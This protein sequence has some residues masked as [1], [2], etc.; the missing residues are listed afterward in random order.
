MIGF[1]FVFVGSASV[2][3]LGILVLQRQANFQVEL[4]LVGLK[5]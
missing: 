3:A 2:A 1:T 4:T 5:T